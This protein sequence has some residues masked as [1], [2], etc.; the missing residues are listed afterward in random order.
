MAAIKLSPGPQQAEQ[1]KAAV[2]E[3]DDKPHTRTP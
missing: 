1:C 2:K 3:H